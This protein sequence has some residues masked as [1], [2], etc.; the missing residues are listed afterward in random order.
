MPIPFTYANWAAPFLIWRPKPRW[1]AGGAIPSL[2]LRIPP[3]P[4]HFVGY[5]GGAQP[6]STEQ[7]F[8]A[9]KGFLGRV[10]INPFSRKT[11]QLYISHQTCRDYCL[12]IHEAAAERSSL[13]CPRLDR[14]GTVVCVRTRACIWFVEVEN[15]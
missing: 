9:V 1:L 10:L 13:C 5:G 2:S 12:I 6:E 11:Q 3:N 14:I 8:G 15:Q 7:V 4:L